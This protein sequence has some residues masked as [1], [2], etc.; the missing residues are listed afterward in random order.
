MGNTP[1]V[2]AKAPLEDEFENVK[3]MHYGMFADGGQ[4][5]CAGDLKNYAYDEEKGDEDL[6]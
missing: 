1:A 2:E 5:V 6:L 3:Y 4:L